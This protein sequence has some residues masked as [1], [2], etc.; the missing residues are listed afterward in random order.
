MHVAERGE[1]G[2]QQSPETW[3]IPIVEHGYRY[4]QII[5]NQGL[6]SLILNTSRDGESREGLREKIWVRKSFFSFFT[7][8]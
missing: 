5:P 6:F 4:A 3:E 2:N 1:E 8:L 7:G